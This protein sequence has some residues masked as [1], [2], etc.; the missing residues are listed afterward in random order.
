M[1][2]WSVT[3]FQ[4]FVLAYTLQKKEKRKKLKKKIH[5]RLF[6][7]TIRCIS[8]ITTNTSEQAFF[9]KLLHHVCVY[10]LIMIN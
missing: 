8:L 1:R 7:I 5:T 6:E 10:S 4:F 3:A 2:C 9:K